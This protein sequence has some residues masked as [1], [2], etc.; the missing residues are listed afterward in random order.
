ME[1]TLV[2]GW[3]GTK[4]REELRSRTIGMPVDEV[5][6]KTVHSRRT[7]C[8]EDLRS[9][10]HKVDVQAPGY[11]KKLDGDSTYTLQCMCTILIR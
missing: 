6:R 2:N 8:M 10:L 11:A 1:T 5:G 4:L 9:E 7:P 3:I